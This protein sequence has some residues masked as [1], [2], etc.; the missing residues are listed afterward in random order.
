MMNQKMVA[1]C[2]FLMMPLAYADQGG[3]FNSGGSL[4]GGSP[5]ANPPGTLTISG[6]NL[7]F[8]TTDGSIAVNA[9][10]S[11]SS[12]VENC[13]GGGKGGHIT[14]S[15]TFKGSFSGT[16]TVNGSTQAIN[17][18]TYQV[19]GTNGV[20]AGGNTGYNSAYTPFYFTDGNARILRSDD[21]NGTNAIAYGTQGTGVGQFYGP[22]GIALDSAGRIYITDTYNDRIVRINDMNGTNWTSFGTYGSGVGQFAIPSSISIDPAGHIWVLDN[23]NGRLVRMDDMNGTNWTVVGGTGSGVG[24]FSSL[25]SAPGFDALGRIYVADAGNN[26]IVRFDDLKFT[27][28]TTLSQSQPVGPYIYT[29]GGPTGVVTG[30]DGKI[31]VAA[32]SSVVRVDDMTGANWTSIGVGTFAPHTMAIDASGMVMLGNGYNAQIVDSEGAVLTSN[33]NG[34]VQGVYVSVYGAVPISLP[35]PRPSAIGFNPPALTFSQNVGSPSA[36]QNIVV[37]NFGGSPISGLSLFATGPFAQTNQCPPTLPA[38]ASCTVSVTFTPASTGDTTG[39]IQV[40]DNSYNMGPSQTL[41]LDGTGTLPGVSV[42]PSPL[43]FSSQLLGTSS[44]ARNVT[45]QSTGTGPLTVA[46]VSVTG[47]FSQTNNCIGSIA[48]AASCSIAVVF[49]PAVVGSASGVLTITDDA[50]TQTVAVSGSGTSPVTFSASSLSF[51][52]L[53]VGSTSAAKTVTVTNRL[54]T[55]LSFAGISV[56]AGGPFAIASN[57]CG[58]GVAAGAN[59]VVGV[60]FTPSATGAASGTLTFA[61]SAINSPQAVSL[62]GTGTAPVTLSASSL[63][64]GTVTVGTTSASKSVTLTNHLSVALTLSPVA[65]TAGFNIASNTCGASVAAGGTCA[66]GV[67]FTPTATGAA[68]GTLTFADSAANSPQTVTL[69]GSGGATSSPVTLSASTLSFGTVTV[70]TTTAATTVT[71]TNHQTVSLSFTSIGITGAFAIAGNTCGTGIG[72]GASCSVGVTFGPT[73]IGAAT[74]TLTFAD[75]ATNSPQKVS[76][77]GTGSAP[78]SLSASALNFGVVAVGSA[79]A[80]QAVTVSNASANA[81]AVNGIAISGDFADT[82]TC[83]ASLPAGGNCVVTVKFAPTVGGARSGTL[84]VNLSTGALSVSLTGAGSSGT[85]QGALTL[86]PSTVTFNNGYTIGNNPR[87]TVTVTNSSGS[88]VGIAAIAM[89]GDASLTQKNNCGTTVAAGGTCAITVTFKPVA[90]GTFAGTL[91]VTEGSGALDSVS[92]KGVS[93]VNN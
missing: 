84:T 51:G 77:S 9:T 4:G 85:L 43:T 34:L 83:T 59:C 19:Y 66:V 2:F 21:L 90:Y 37:T 35:S 30:P 20:V 7:T 11:T 80:G 55:A 15:F 64:F 56:A 54:S 73:A 26:W 89:S 39:T 10:F 23:G 3:F 5:V 88:A 78:V 24:Q 57:T 42:T 38:A 93:T 82:S 33:I 92:V 65:I 36:A 68:T 71:V 58:T 29:F 47:P 27:N 32:G 31:Y 8:V 75:N 62:S 76:L 13:A 60:T 61:D 63:S 48:P 79:S 67:T 1:V 91:T 44:T 53:A 25:S 14:C 12:T 52:S 49:S 69:S 46:N 74:G 22:S 81:V 17:G 40:N 50:G 6:N 28:W 16:L 87:Q 70:G 45:L 41:A 86:S 18:S 72:A